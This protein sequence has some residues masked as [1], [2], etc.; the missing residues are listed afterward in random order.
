M[1]TS[2][3]IMVQ[4]EKEYI[5][6]CLNGIY[7]V[8]DEII[9]I[10]DIKYSLSGEEIVQ[11]STIDLINNYSDPDDKIVKIFDTFYQSDLEPLENEARIRNLAKESTRIKPDLF[12]IVDADEIW[13]PKILRSS[14]EYIASIYHNTKDNRFRIK[15]LLLF[16]KLY[17]GETLA[18]A[19]KNRNKFYFQ[20]MTVAFKPELKF[21]NGRMLIGTSANIE[22]L[23]HDIPLA[24]GLFEHHSHIKDEKRMY[25][26]LKHWGHANDRSEDFFE[27]WFKN[28]WLCADLHTKNVGLFHPKK[29]PR[30]RIYKSSMI[31]GIIKT[32]NELT[33][34]NEPSGFF[35]RKIQTKRSYLINWL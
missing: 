26:K 5:V 16:R 9:I 2:A 30:L 7:E 20:K 17:N 4:N 29:W 18:V 6:K 19:L 27:H 34:E 8:F 22:T 11:D 12:F 3:I 15:C 1:K 35:R 14:L 10:S 28:K 33:I 21:G 13:I 32:N 25:E 23:T 24:N 31:E